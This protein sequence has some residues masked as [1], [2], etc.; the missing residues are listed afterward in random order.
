VKEKK[1]VLQE[2]QKSSSLQTK[3]A[4]EARQGKQNPR[5]SSFDKRRI[6]KYCSSGFTSY[7]FS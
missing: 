6:K 4:K 7:F 5:I 1:A 2:N 3:A